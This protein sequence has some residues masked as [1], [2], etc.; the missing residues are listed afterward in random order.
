[1]DMD[2]VNSA[3]LARYLPSVVGDQWEE[4]TDAAVTFLLRSIMGTG[5]KDVKVVAKDL[6]PPSS[7]DKLKKHLR[8]LCDRLEKGALLVQKK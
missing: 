7:T 5:A 4:S 6:V 3:M 8:L 1:M 2:E